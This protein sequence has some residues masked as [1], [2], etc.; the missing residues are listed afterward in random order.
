MRNIPL[1]SD[2]DGGN[3]I[4]EGAMRKPGALQIDPGRV[5]G[6]GRFRSFTCFIPNELVHT[7]KHTSKT[8]PLP[9]RTEIVSQ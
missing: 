1:F 2:D 7:Y 4:E 3:K 8:Q 9:R 5:G 6:L